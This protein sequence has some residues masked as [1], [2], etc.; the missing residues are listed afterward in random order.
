[1]TVLFPVT[2]VATA[3]MGLVSGPLVPRLIAWVPEPEP[4]PEPEPG[5]EPEP[6]PEPEPSSLSRPLRPL[7]RARGAEGAYADI[8]ARPRLP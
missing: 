7:A 8:A 5:P 4:E 3:A 6:E 2:A 1:M